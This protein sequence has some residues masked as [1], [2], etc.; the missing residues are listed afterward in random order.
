MSYYPEQPGQPPHGGDAWGTPGA[1]GNPQNPLNP[2]PAA[3]TIYPDSA[4]PADQYYGAVQP[5]SGAP[6]SGQPYGQP[7]Y[8]ASGPPAGPYPPGPAYYGAPPAYGY[9]NQQWSD[10]TKVVAGI[11]QLLP[12]I[13]VGIG[14]IGRLYAGQIG[15]GIAQLGITVLGWA[16][17][18]CGFLLILPFFV[19]GA[20]WVWFVIDGIVLLAGTP[21]DGEGRLLR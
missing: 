21:R 8:A 15:F 10:K 18:W 20:I 2:D 14:G 1:P 3:Y 12:A 16:A 5:Y 17:F 11:L 13:F 4:P 9:G 6:Q 7:P 19:E